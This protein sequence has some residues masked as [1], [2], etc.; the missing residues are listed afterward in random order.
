MLELLI[1]VQELRGCCERA[2]RNRQLTPGEKDAVR[3]FKDLVRGCLPAVVLEQY[4]HLKKAE[5]QL[6]ECPEIFGMAVLVSTYRG[7]SPA[8]RKKL[9]AHFATRPPTML[10]YAGRNGT[11][12]SR[13]NKGL[14]RRGV[15]P[16]CHEALQFTGPEAR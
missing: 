14:H 1:R 15:R 8:K 13:G 9:L 16:K 12:R 10:L 11:P 4:D 2:A 3:D 7:L 6:L 5:S